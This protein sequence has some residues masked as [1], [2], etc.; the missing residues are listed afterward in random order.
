[1]SDKIARAAYPVCLDL[2]GGVRARVRIVH[3]WDEAEQ[4]LS[5]L[6][7]VPPVYELRDGTTV[8]VDVAIPDDLRAAGW[9]WNGSL[10]TWRETPES[11][12]IAV[13]TCTFP[14]PG[15]PLD[16][17]HM[18]DCMSQARVFEQLRGTREITTKEKPANK[19]SRSRP[20]IGCNSIASS[21]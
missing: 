19:S 10:L 8:D 4:T 6:V 2:P 9:Y 3:V 13:A 21:R 17:T 5:Q 15:W 1:M 11:C 18:T 7:S 20:P 16:A 12:G 14:P